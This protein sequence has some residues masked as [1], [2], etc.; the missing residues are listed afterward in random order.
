LKIENSPEALERIN[1]IEQLVSAIAEFSEENKGSRIEDFLTK[2]SLVSDID[3]LDNKKNAV[4]LM[5]I[6][7]AK[8]LEFK[9]IF[10]TGL[11][12]G[13]FPVTSA[14]MQ[15]D[16]LEEERRLFYVAITRAKEK[17]YI[18]FANQRNRFGT[19]SYQMK[20]RFL[21]ELPTD[22]LAQNAIFDGYKLYQFDRTYQKSTKKKENN[23]G[24][25]YES[26]KFN[27]F[28][29]NFEI[30]DKFPE[31]KKG[32][33]IYHE[34]YGNGKVLS[35]TGKGIDKKAEIYFEDM[36]VMKIILKYAKLRVEE[37]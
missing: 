22:I 18:S 19:P 4:T 30:D 21:K 7:A 26:I 15:E 29:D 16:E 9:I 3:N 31:I 6:H 23:K 17:L 28:K 33:K 1:N 34:K 5:T 36:G 10:I 11:E 27:P 20:S 12:E 37:E 35:T 2:V 24:F 25:R 8:G 32:V 13:L 14:I